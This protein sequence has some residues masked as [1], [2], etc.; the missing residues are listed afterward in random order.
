MWMASA[1][2]AGGVSSDE[3]DRV[4]GSRLKVDVVRRR[5]IVYCQRPLAELLCKGQAKL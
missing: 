1:E 3:N 2:A 4:C 5:L